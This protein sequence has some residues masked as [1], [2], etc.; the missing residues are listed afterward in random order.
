MTGCA[1]SGDVCRCVELEQK[2][3]ELEE[4]VGAYQ[5]ALQRISEVRGKSMGLY[6][7]SDGLES[8]RSIAREALRA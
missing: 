4:T 5:M 6:Y 7:G 3:E 2:I 8:F 1:C